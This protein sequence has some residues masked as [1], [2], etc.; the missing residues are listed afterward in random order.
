[1]RKQYNFWPGEHGLDAWDVDRLVELSAHLP[2]KDVAI[3]AIL[4]VD[5]DYWF[6]VRTVAPHGPEGGRAHPVG[7]RGRPVVADHLGVVRPRHGRHA[8]RRPGDARR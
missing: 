8:P 7:R 5:T 6:A 2:V 3:D 1:M 4:D